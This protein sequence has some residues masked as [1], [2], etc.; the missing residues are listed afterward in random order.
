MTSVPFYEFES[1]VRVFK[2]CGLS[3]DTVLLWLCAWNMKLVFISA[4]LN[5]GTTVTVTASSPTS[6]DIGTSQYLFGDKPVLN[7]FNR[8]QNRNL[9]SKHVRHCWQHKATSQSRTECNFVFPHQNYFLTMD[10][11][12]T[13]TTNPSTL[14]QKWNTRGWRWGEGLQNLT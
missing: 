12:T 7:K 9:V 13:T 8:N 3:V 10:A 5:A 2:S 14:R 4:H 1:A 6:W 11:T